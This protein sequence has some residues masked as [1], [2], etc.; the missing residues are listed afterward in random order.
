MRVSHLVIKEIKYRKLS[1]ALGVLSIAVA[2][3]VLVGQV[4]ALRDHDA[5]T[6]QLIAKKQHETDVR[7][8]EVSSEVAQRVAQRQAEVQKR[9]AELQDDYRKITKGLGF[10][11]FIFPEGQDLSQVYSEGFASK[12]MPE[13]YVERLAKH[14]PPIVTIDHLLPTLT[15]KI[16]WQEK[17]RTIILVGTRQ[18]LATTPGKAKPPVIPTPKPGEAFV[19]YEL[20]KSLGIQKHDDIVIGGRTFSARRLEPQKGTTDDITI[21]IDLAVA[22]EMLGLKGRINA[23]LALEC[24]CA[25]ADRIGQIR[26]EIAQ[27]LPGTQVIE[28]HGSALAR[29]E[30]RNRAQKEAEA[31]LAAAQTQGEQDIQ[32]AR[33]QGEQAVAQERQHRLDVREQSAALVRWVVPL[34]ILGAAVWVGLLMYA[35]VRERR[36]E[37]G[38][39]RA[40]GLRGRDI[41]SAMVGKA[42][43]IGI[44]G[45]VVGS[46]G[47]ILIAR[48]WNDPAGATV[49]SPALLAAVLVGAPLLAIMAS[50]LPA[51]VAARQDPAVV[52][53]RES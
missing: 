52:L 49:V 18:E 9:S 42:V 3:G 24:N 6:E 39:L 29:A 27:A 43:L 30:A 33:L 25:A 51:M 40:I 44:V 15:Q 19:G 45:A 50:A 23:I 17:Q 53:Q 10:N 34:V 4:S 11:I 1:F 31:A 35:N 41:L 14:D 26:Q 48:F 32:A 22:Q 28:L 36:A 38:I 8:A 13:D 37:I 21:W 7:V 47:G 12:T 5:R 2:A 46:A 20:H 16:T